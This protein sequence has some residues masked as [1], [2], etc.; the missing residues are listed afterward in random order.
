MRT[1]AATFDKTVSGVVD[2]VELTN[3]VFDLARI[4]TA[5]LAA[6]NGFQEISI[7]QV[8]ARALPGRTSVALEG[9]FL[10]NC[11]HYEL[12]VRDL[13][14]AFIS[15]VSTKLTAFHHIPRAI[16]DWHPRGCAKIMLE[17]E[18]DKFQHLTADTIT[19]AISSCETASI[20][21]PYRFLLDAFSAHERNLSANVVEDMLARRLGIDKIWQRLSH[22]PEMESYF[23]TN[24]HEMLERL[25][26]SRL[27]DLIQR[28]N[29]IIH[30]GRATYAISQTELVEASTFLRVL[31]TS[32]AEIMTA[33]LAA[34]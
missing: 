3:A 10:S 30:R 8:K 25:S 17:L 9:A 24:N 4:D 11:A 6:Q 31:I 27:D 29:G 33:V 21:A 14:E 22:R 23:G 16:R 34:L 13:I 28:R 15:Q 20:K 19:K 7:V 12:A 26:R 1:V 32:L 2:F 5:H 18:R